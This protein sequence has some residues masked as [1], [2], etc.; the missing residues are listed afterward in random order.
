VERDIRS[1]WGIRFDAGWSNSNLAGSAG[2]QRTTAAVSLT[3]R[4]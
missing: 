2:F 1:H 3:I 4:P